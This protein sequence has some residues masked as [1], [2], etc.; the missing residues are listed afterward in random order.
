MALSDASC[1][2][3]SMNEYRRSLDTWNDSQDD[4]PDEDDDQEQLQ[5]MDDHDQFDDPPETWILPL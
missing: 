4:E 3:G 2:E 1:S 5:V